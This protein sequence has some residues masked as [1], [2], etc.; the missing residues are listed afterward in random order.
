MSDKK[1]VSLTGQLV[2]GCVG[3]E[4]IAER[5]WHIERV[6]VLG[7]IKT[8]IDSGHL[9]TE[10]YFKTKPLPFN[11]EQGPLADYYTLRISRPVKK[12]WW[13]RKIRHHPAAPFSHFQLIEEVLEGL[14]EISLGELFR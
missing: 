8:V 11:T 4:G 12:K 3:D 10:G 6:V 14:E 7:E 13:H 9:D 2:F 1:G 5:I